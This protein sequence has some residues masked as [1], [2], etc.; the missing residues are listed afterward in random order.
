[1]EFAHLWHCLPNWPLS[2][3]WFHLSSFSSSSPSLVISCCLL[4]V[5]NLIMMV[6]WLAALVGSFSTALPC[7]DLTLRAT[8]RVESPSQSQIQSPESLEVR[9]CLSAV[10]FWSL[11][12]CK[13]LLLL[14]ALALR[15]P[16]H[17]YIK[18][19]SYD[20]NSHSHSHSKSDSFRIRTA[21]MNCNHFCWPSWSWLSIFTLLLCLHAANC[22]YALF[23]S[24]S[25]L[26]LLFLLLHTQFITTNLNVSLCV[27][28][29]YGVCRCRSRCRCGGRCIWE[30]WGDMMAN[31]RV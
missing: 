11:K 23:S 27:R 8:D 19:T 18:W 5:D 29:F 6:G 24:S 28:H 17:A 22:R 26:Y 2:C 16:L 20:N 4:C 12:L 21:V 9:A 10:W 1:M 30:S 25:L 14:S 31:E 7:L 3:L 15:K 13:L